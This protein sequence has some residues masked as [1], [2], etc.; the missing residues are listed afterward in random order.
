MR[1]CLLAKDAGSGEWVLPHLKRGCASFGTHSGVSDARL[2]CSIAKSV[3]G[4]PN[5]YE[6]G[7]HRISDGQGGGDV[8]FRVRCAGL[9]AT[10]C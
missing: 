6:A 3:T 9:G 1:E 10:R 4:L 8:I 5:G 7:L 2:A